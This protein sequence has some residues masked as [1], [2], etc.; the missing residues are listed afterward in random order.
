MHFR[1]FFRIFF[2][3]G[4]EF[5]PLF[6]C[7]CFFCLFVFVF[8]YLFLWQQPN[9]SHQLKKGGKKGKGGEMVEGNGEKKKQ[10]KLYFLSHM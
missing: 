3:V 1:A 8:V 10:K 7:F 4:F 6:C 5:L 9:I 2:F